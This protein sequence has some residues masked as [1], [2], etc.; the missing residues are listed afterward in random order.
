MLFAE[1]LTTIMDREEARG[2]HAVDLGAGAF[3]ARD[4]LESF[5]QSVGRGLRPGNPS[6]P[7][8]DFDMAP[9]PPVGGGRRDD[10]VA[11][12]RGLLA[13]GLGFD[14]ASPE[15]RAELRNVLD[16]DGDP[17]L[18]QVMKTEDPKG[19]FSL[20]IPEP[21][22]PNKPEIMP[23]WARIPSLRF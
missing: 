18:L 12:M 15:L 6:V 10:L 3:A 11:E 20:Y 7:A 2:V 5:R 23:D 17:E 22:Q 19:E 21:P 1:M 8:L 9:A 13:R 16:G 14:A 4:D